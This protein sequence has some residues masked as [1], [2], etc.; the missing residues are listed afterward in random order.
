ML[1]GESGDKEAARLEEGADAACIEKV[2][3]AGIEAHARRA[4]PPLGAA[5]AEAELPDPL[6]AGEPHLRIE[7]SPG[8]EERGGKGN[9]DQYEIGE[10]AACCTVVRGGRRQSKGPTG[11]GG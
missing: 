11:R 9:H 2:E 1:V 6:Q 10:G 4:I 5:F 7:Q 3:P 8:R